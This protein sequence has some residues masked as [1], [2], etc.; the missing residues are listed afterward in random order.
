MTEVI[1][2]VPQQNEVKIKIPSLKICLHQIIAD[3]MDKNYTYLAIVLSKKTMSLLNPSGVTI[4]SS[5][6]FTLKITK[7]YDGKGYAIIPTEIVSIFNFSKGQKVIVNLVF[8]QFP[9]ETHSTQNQK[10]KCTAPKTNSWKNPHPKPNSIICPICNRLVHGSLIT[11]HHI[12][13]R[14]FKVIGKRI[15]EKIMEDRN[16]I[17]ICCQCNV[18]FPRKERTKILN[19][20]TKF[21]KEFLNT[22]QNEENLNNFAEELFL[23]LLEKCKQLFRLNHNFKS[24]VEVV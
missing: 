19:H 9:Q 4:V 7:R 1:L 8:S 24:N 18:R 10:R 14:K 2:E 11:S 12:V 23:E 6:P 22:N 20:Y 3:S 15:F 16:H 17:F 5:P 21:W 13:P